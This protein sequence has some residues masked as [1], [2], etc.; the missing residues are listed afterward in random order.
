MSFASVERGDSDS[1][2]GMRAGRQG[3]RMPSRGLEERGIAR[4]AGLNCQNGSNRL[5]VST[6]WSNGI[7]VLLLG[8][9]SCWYVKKQTGYVGSRKL[10][11]KDGSTASGSSIQWN[12]LVSSRLS[13][14]C[15]FSHSLCFFLSA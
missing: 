13:C 8:E 2:V 14:S 12:S 1:G 5:N 4:I 11:I 6:S 3:Q 10:N 7:S 15:A 9:M